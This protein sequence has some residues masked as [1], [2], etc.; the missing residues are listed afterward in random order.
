MTV[1]PEPQRSDY[2]PDPDGSRYFAAMVRW[3]AEKKREETKELLRRQHN[4][5]RPLSTKL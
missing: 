2:W 5:L 1:R 3:I 4:A